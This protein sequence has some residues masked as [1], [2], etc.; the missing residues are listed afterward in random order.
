MFW[1]AD[2]P[3]HQSIPY[4][5]HSKMYTKRGSYNSVLKG[6]GKNQNYDQTDKKFSDNIKE[7]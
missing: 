1:L 5:V 2:F 4:I 7:T 6:G 3:F